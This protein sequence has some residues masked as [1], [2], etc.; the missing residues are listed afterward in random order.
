MGT[1]LFNDK[2]PH[3]ES[4]FLRKIHAHTGMSTYTHMYLEGK[5][6]V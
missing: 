4:S 2:L 1:A 6:Q 3:E 5:A